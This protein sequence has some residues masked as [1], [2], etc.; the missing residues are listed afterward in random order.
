M[1]LGTR[2]TPLDFA[3]GFEYIYMDV[4]PSH[5]GLDDFVESS[6]PLLHTQSVSLFALVGTP[7]AACR[8]SSPLWTF[9]SLVMT[10][11]RSLKRSRAPRALLSLTGAISSPKC[12]WNMRRKHRGPDEFLGTLKSFA[13]LVHEKQCPLRPAG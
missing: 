1:S 2:I 4:S 12:C 6:S 10:G 9:P 7:P 8:L 3:V 13:C 11:T 5:L